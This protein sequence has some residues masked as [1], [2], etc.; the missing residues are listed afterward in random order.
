MR[1]PTHNHIAPLRLLVILLLYLPHFAFLAG[2]QSAQQPAKN[3]P[4]DLTSEDTVANLLGIRQVSAVHI[5]ILDDNSDNWSDEMITIT[6]SSQINELTASLMELPR[7]IPR[8]RC[9]PQFRLIFHQPHATDVQLDYSCD[10]HVA[11]FIR[12]EQHFWSGQD[13]EAPDKFAEWM[14]AILDEQP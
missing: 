14:R 11:N 5:L 9:V 2:C 4:I 3:A 1:I 8:V 12:G 10:G 7:F 6:D 13:A